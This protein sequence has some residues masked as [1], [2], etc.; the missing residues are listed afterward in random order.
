MVALALV[1]L[2]AIDTERRNSGDRFVL[3]QK[4]PEGYITIGRAE[5][6]LFINQ[7]EDRIDTIQV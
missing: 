1:L 4:N 6:Y 2:L 3:D 7:R 5:T